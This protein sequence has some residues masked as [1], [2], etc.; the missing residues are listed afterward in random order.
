M[1]LVSSNWRDIQKYYDQCFIKIRDF[2]DKIF[3][4][5]KVTP[6]FV[7]FKDK[8]GQEGI[9]HLHDEV[10]YNLDMV[11]PHKA[12]FQIGDYA[13]LM[14]RI[15]ARQYN[16]GITSQNCTIKKLSLSGWTNSS[17]SFM[18]LSGYT[19]KTAYRPADVVFKR[20]QGS[21]VLSARFAYLAGTYS[22]YCDTKQVAT[23]D[24]VNKRIMCRPLIEAELATI[25]GPN[26]EYK[27]I[28]K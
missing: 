18:N 24:P 17:V 6:E 8:D 11:L 3:F 15:P 22:I 13:Y 26:S 25:L 20:E 4:V 1:Q 27:L 28:V 23:L 14:Q 2:G 5:D 16:R 12:M 21:E 10:P 7:L 9:I 19:E